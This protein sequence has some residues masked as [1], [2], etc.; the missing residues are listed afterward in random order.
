MKRFV[1]IVLAAIAL[2]GCKEDDNNDPVKVKQIEIDGR[3]YEIRYAKYFDG[4]YEFIGEDCLCLHIE[5]L[6]NGEN[7]GAGMT[8]EISKTLLGR[9][10]PV[11]PS[12]TFWFF[13]A[14]TG[15]KNFSIESTYPAEK[16]ENRK[17]WFYVDY[18]KNEDE[19]IFEWEISDPGGD[20]T[21]TQ[22]YI[23][24][25]FERISEL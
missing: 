16:F 6:L 8:V 4:F 18:G 5:L 22:G 1:L 19:I 9:Q 2:F 11:S 3:E 24:S 10:I 20:R 14:G 12:D 15:Q 25:V 21:S 17:G 23:E 13:H 7:T